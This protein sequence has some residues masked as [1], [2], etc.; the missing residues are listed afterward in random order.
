MD[1]A[2]EHKIAEAAEHGVDLMN[3]EVE[4]AEEDFCRICRAES[5]LDQP[6]FHPCK[7]SGSVAFVHQECLKEWLRHSQKKHCEL[8]KTHFR[9]TKLYDPN[10]P[11][12]IPIFVIVTRFSQQIVSSII[13]WMRAMLVGFVWLGALPLTVKILWQFFFNLADTILLANPVL[14]TSKENATSSSLASL[15]SSPKANMLLVFT[16][17]GQI[18][19][20]IVSVCFIAAFLVREWVV[21]NAMNMFLDQNP[22][23]ARQIEALQQGIDV[24]EDANQARD[25]PNAIPVPVEQEVI[26]LNGLAI[27]TVQLEP[28]D[29]NRDMHADGPSEE[30]A[31]DRRKNAIKQKFLDRLKQ[32]RGERG[33]ASAQANGGSIADALAPEVVLHEAQESQ[34]LE[35][36]SADLNLETPETLTPQQYMDAMEDMED[37]VPDEL[38]GSTGEGTENLNQAEPAHEQRMN[39]PRRRN[40]WNLFRA[41]EHP[42]EELHV[43]AAPAEGQND[44]HEAHHDEMEVMEAI[45]DD[46][47]DD[48]EGIME[49]IGM[50]G[51]IFAL[52]S[53]VFFTCVLFGAAMCAGI[54]I[55]YFSGKTLIIMMHEPYFYLVFIPLKCF[56]FASEFMVDL[57]TIISGFLFC[58]AIW[59]LNAILSVASMPHSRMV[60][61]VHEA[62]GRFTW[63]SWERL[64]Q[65]ISVLQSL[66]IGHS[67]S[68]PQRSSPSFLLHIT[69]QNWSLPIFMNSRERLLCV[70]IGYLFI[71]LCGTL[72]LRQTVRWTREP[73]QNG[74]RRALGD[75]LRQTGAVA[76]IIFVIGIELA[77]FPTFCGILLDLSTLPLFEGATVD[78]RLKFYT[79]FPII[80]G[81]LHWFV[82][83][84]YMFH[85]AMFVSMCREIVRPGTLCKVE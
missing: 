40:I 9:F 53:N 37:G 70:A 66:A 38:G 23:P 43:G 39:Q 26:E 72:I 77:I 24:Q 13:M 79:V 1:A 45:H 28:D 73:W 68:W 14:S 44:G 80:S 71:T 69:A 50:R 57:F 32:A 21:Q 6:L 60:D 48:A 11:S 35:T 51:P 8:C 84:C 65:Q 46:G 54:F 83:T 85:F 33:S 78:S 31:L 10:M 20:A 4:P 25:V 34:N 64:C 7:C 62:M 42:A 19:A 56:R 81:F 76:K 18:L 5:T 29:R 17:H 47:M 74:A 59:A 41:Q 15:T 27:E 16:F 61:G 63:H 67:M 12:S 2:A 55:P 58:L 22:E 49:L 30:D 3:E 82:G 52:F 75:T 36:L